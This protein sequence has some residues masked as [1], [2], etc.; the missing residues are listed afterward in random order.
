MATGGQVG[1]DQSAPVALPLTHYPASV[2]PQNRSR[3][4]IAILAAAAVVA[5]LVAGFAVLR[6]RSG[7]PDAESVTE[8]DETDDD[9]TITTP[10]TDPA[11]VLT[12]P[13]ETRLVVPTIDVPSVTVELTT[14]EGWTYEARLPIP[15]FGSILVQKNLK[16][17][18][19][20]MARLEYTADLTLLTPVTA[21]STVSDR[22]APLVR[23]DPIAWITIP[24]DLVPTEW[25]E[26]FH[27]QGGDFCSFKSTKFGSSSSASGFQCVGFTDGAVTDDNPETLIDS[28]L[29]LF[30][31]NAQ[32]A[33]EYVSDACDVVVFADGSARIVPDFPDECE[34][35]P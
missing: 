2:A 26:E 12:V 19:P 17:S 24:D 34:L 23:F 10:E 31:A 16:T 13:T 15:S 32:V 1:V 35:L 30:E 18:P 14:E 7:G 29:S 9:G 21:V 33:V 3:Q 28:V 6:P 22:E 5:V 4:A 27:S 20:G 25:K 11:S 8:V